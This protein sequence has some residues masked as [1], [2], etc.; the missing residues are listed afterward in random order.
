MS[1]DLIE[2]T[3]PY[4]RII[5]ILKD[6]DWDGY[7]LSEYEGRNKDVPGYASD[8]IRRQ[9]VMMKRYLGEV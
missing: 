6:N 9:H 5:Q 3:I 1:D 8:Q 7:L 2:T 4:D